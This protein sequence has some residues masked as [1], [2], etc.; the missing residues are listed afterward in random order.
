MRVLRDIFMHD[1]KNLGQVFTPPNIVADMLNL[2]HNNGRFLEPSTGDGAFF[3]NLPSNKIGI[4]IDSKFA[5]N[6]V[7]N[8]DFFSYPI[9]EKFDTIIGN[10]P[11]VRYQDIDINTKF[12]LSGYADLFD[13]RSNLYLY[14]K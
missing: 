1:I 8:I 13:E 2:I 7:L 10:P 4:E 14:T 5:P 9:S 3:N 11:Y 6:D 12:L